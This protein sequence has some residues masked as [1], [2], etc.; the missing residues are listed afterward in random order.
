[1]GGIWNNVNARVP[2]VIAS[3]DT[4]V[5]TVPAMLATDNSGMVTLTTNA[6]DAIA[7]Q[8]NALCD[9]GAIVRFGETYSSDKYVEVTLQ[10]LQ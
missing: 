5:L 10:P 6:G 7:G 3:S 4:N 1:M 9:G 8:G 2:V